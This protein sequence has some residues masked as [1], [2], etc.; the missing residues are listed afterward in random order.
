[1]AKHS[2][3]GAASD[4]A[5]RLAKERFAEGNVGDYRS[6]QAM[7]ERIKAQILSWAHSTSKHNAM[8]RK[9]HFQSTSGNSNNTSYTISPQFMPRPHASPNYQGSPAKVN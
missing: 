4:G 8:L 6:G 3:V 1:M 9:T 2:I 5:R 7:V